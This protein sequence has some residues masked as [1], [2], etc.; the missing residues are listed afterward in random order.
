MPQNKT[1][2][3]AGQTLSTHII[4]EAIASLEAAFVY[5]HSGAVPGTPLECEVVPIL[6]GLP[7]LPDHD[8]ADT[9]KFDKI[10]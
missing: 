1:V 3:H 10:V 9:A 8:G 7:L 5:H 6:A 2:F 4:R